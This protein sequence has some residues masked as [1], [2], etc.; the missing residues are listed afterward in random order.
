MFGFGNWVTRLGFFLQFWFS[1]EVEIQYYKGDIFDVSFVL[2][3]VVFTFLSYV[4]R[5]V[6]EKRL[7]GYNAKLDS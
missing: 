6:Y 2:F 3:G 5:Y 1:L 4:R 7:L